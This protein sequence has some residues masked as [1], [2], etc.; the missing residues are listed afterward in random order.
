M[1]NMIHGLAGFCALGL[2]STTPALG[3]AATDVKCDG[4]VQSGDIAT[5]GVRRADIQNFSINTPKLN[6]FAVTTEKI[7]TGAVTESKIAD[8]A[9]TGGKI[10]ANAVGITQID[11]T[12]VQIRVADSCAV[13]SFIAAIAEDGSVNCEKGGTAA[14]LTAN[15]NDLAPDVAVVDQQLFWLDDCLTAPY[16]AGP[17]ETALVTASVGFTLNVPIQGEVII[18]SFVAGAPT[19]YGNGYLWVSDKGDITVVHHIALA[20]GVEYRFGATIF[21]QGGGVTR[22]RLACQTMAQIV[23]TTP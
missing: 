21:P 16:V 17:G 3:Q 11:P 14:V 19:T 8:G 20:E 23:R 6:N 5:N 4:C 18:S 2:L 13:G 22:S 12:E 7:K 9:V 1:R 15:G 10:A